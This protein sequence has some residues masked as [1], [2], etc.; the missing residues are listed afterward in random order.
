VRRDVAAA[1]HKAEKHRSYQRKE[2]RDFCDFHFVTAFLYPE[3]FGE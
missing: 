1:G 2:C 3:S